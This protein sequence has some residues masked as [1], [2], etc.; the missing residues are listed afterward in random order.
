[1]LLKLM[2]KKKFV[3][4][5]PLQQIAQSLKEEQKKLPSEASFSDVR[6]EDPESCSLVKSGMKY[7]SLTLSN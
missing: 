1:M 6:L 7:I 4:Y 3:V 5:L 2:R